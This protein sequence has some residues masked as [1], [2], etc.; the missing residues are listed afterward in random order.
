MVLVAGGFAVLMGYFALREFMMLCFK[1][2][3]VQV[4]EHGLSIAGITQDEIGWSDIFAI[5]P[6]LL[7]SS[8]TP[9]TRL[10]STLFN[11]IFFALSPGSGGS[12]VAGYAGMLYGPYFAFKVKSGAMSKLNSGA[13][14][15]FATLG[16]LSGA[17]VVRIDCATLAESIDIIG[18]AVRD[19]KNEHWHG[20]VD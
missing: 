19:A 8:F 7:A 2:A 16:V 10:L 14:L 9:A 1:D 3:A 17:D 12:S 20:R 6:P 11:F 4:T 13:L 15:R 5:D 18:A